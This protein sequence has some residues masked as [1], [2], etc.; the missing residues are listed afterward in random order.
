[1]VAEQTDV[2]AVSEVSLFSAPASGNTDTQRG[3]PIEITVDFD[4]L[5]RITGIPQVNLTVGSSTRAA[6][7]T[8]PATHARRSAS[9]LYLEY[10]VVAAESDSG[11]ISVAAG[12]AV[13]NAAGHR[14]DASLRDTTPASGDSVAVTSTL[15]KR[16]TY[17]FGET[18][19]RP[20]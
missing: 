5:V 8:G 13:R 15:Q 17:M 14:V 20:S 4:R 16:C 19:S 12:Y 7:L 18:I 2:P 3:D 11:G 9:S 10:T 6:G 1:M